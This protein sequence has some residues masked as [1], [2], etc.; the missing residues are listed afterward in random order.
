[1]PTESLIFV[2]VSDMKMHS[3][4]SALQ[5]HICVTVQTKILGERNATVFVFN[6][7]IRA[8]Q[9]FCLLRVYV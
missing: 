4:C 3:W 1:M 2:I 5:S 6:T 7:L 9:S 8:A